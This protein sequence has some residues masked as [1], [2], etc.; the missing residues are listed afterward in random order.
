MLPSL[1]AEELRDALASYLG[2]TFALADD[3]VRERLEAFLTDPVDGIFRGPYVRLRLPF[4]PAAEG[5]EDVL[6]WAPP[7][8]RPYHHQAEAFRRL[9]SKHG[10]P[11][12]TLVTTGTGSGK[13]EAF[14]IPLLDHCRRARAAGQPGIKA[15]VLYPMNALANDQAQRIDALLR[16]NAEELGEITVGLYTGDAEA[17][18][19][20][21]ADSLLRQRRELRENPPDILLTNYKMLDFL[22]LRPEDAELWR[23]SRDSLQYVVLDE[24]HTYDGAQGTDVAMLLRRLSMTLGV[25]RPGRPLGQ[26]TP[27]ATSATLGDGGETNSTLLDFAGR[28]FG[29]PFDATAVIR[30]NRLSVEE[31]L[32]DAPPVD[33]FTYEALPM[34][35]QL[36]PPTPG[37]PHL[38]RLAEVARVFLRDPAATGGSAWGNPDP[39]IVSDRHRL[40][41]RLKHHPLTAKLLAAAA[42][43]RPLGDLV[44]EVAPDWVR[45]RDAAGQRALSDFLA[46]LSHARSGDRP[47]LQVEI[48]LWI[49]EVSRIDRAV[50][51]VPDFRWGSDSPRTD[52][53]QRYLP[54]IYCRHCGRSG[55]GA[56]RRSS[57][58]ALD[59]NPQHIRR[60][61]ARN[62]GRFRALIYAPGEDQAGDRKALSWLDP[63]TLELHARRPSEEHEL[64]P[65]LVTSDD[66]AA[67]KERCPS[68]GLD[69][70]IRFLGSRVATLTSVAVGHVFASPDVDPEQ[71]KTLLFTDSVQDAAHRAGFIEARSYTLN[72]RSLLHRALGGDQGN[73]AEIGSKLLNAATTPEDR[74][75]LLPP[76]MA[77]DEQYREFWAS[78]RCSQRIRSEVLNRV[79]FGAI[80]EFGLHAR[81]G[82]TLEL[83]GTITAH[84]DAE[85]EW[86]TRVARDV[87]A[88]HREERPQFEELSGEG[89]LLGW[90]RGVLERMRLQGGI[91]HRWLHRYI[92]EDGRR[93]TIWGG[94]PEGMPAFPSGRPAPAF[95]TTVARYE[96][97]DSVVARNTWYT[98]WTART[99]EIPESEAPHLVRR[100]FEHL[101]AEN[102]ISAQATQSGATVYYLE[103]DQV[104]LTPLDTEPDGGV[105]LRCDVCSLRFPGIAEIAQQL[106]DRPCLRNRCPGRL[107]E[108][109][110]GPD[111]Y[112][113][114]YSSGRVRRI[115]T[116]E[117]TGLLDADTRVRVEKAF[118]TSQDP[119]APNV[120][121]CT[122]TLELGIDIG[123]L[124]VVGLTSLPRTV[125]GYLQRVGRAGRQTGNALVLAVLPGRGINL[126]WLSEPLEM[127]AGEVIPPACYLDAAEIL[128]RQYF[129]SLVDRA[130]RT[131]RGRPPRTAGRMLPTALARGSWLYDLLQDARKNAAVYVE[132]FLAGFRGHITPAT[133]AMLAEWAGVGL[134]AT[135]IS[136]MERTVEA[137]VRRWNDDFAELGVRAQALQNEIRRLEAQ[138]SIL[139]DE[140]ERDL[141][142]VRGEYRI[143]VSERRAMAREYWISAFEALGLLPN[144]NLLDDRTRLDVSLTWTDE[145]TGRA[146]VER[147]SYERGSRIALE[148][149]A[150]GN[151]FY[152]N[153]VA[154]SVDAVDLG[155]EH[156][157]NLGRWRFCPS[158]GW[159]APNSRPTACPRCHDSRAADTGQVLT[160]V[161]FRRASAFASRDNA[162]FGDEDEER[163]RTR[164]T[165]LSAVDVAPQRITRAW[166]LRDYPFGAEYARA[167][168]IR[169][170]NLGRQDGGGAEQQI[171]GETVQAPLFVVCRY[172]GVV[173]EAQPRVHDVA[174]ARHRGWC[175]Q[176][177]EP[178]P[179]GWVSVALLHELR[180]EVVRLLVPPIVIADD[181]LL[182]SVRAA[183]LLGLRK[184]LGGEPDH[185]DVLIA[186]DPGHRGWFTLVLHDR[187]PG[188]TGYLA[189][190][191]DPEAVRALL[192]AAAKALED[193]PCA[194]QPIKAC[195]RCLLPY[196]PPWAVPDVRRDLA[197]GL[198]RDILAAWQPQDLTSL[199]AIAVSPHETP[200][201]QRL[202][203][204]LTQWA[205][206]QN[207]DPRLSPGPGGDQLTFRL[208][209]AEGTRT[210]TMV[211]QPRLG[212][213]QPDFVLQADDPSVPEIAVFCDGRKYHATP[214]HNRLADD[215]GKRASLREQG[216]LVWAIT[217]EDLDSFDEVLRGSPSVG[218]AALTE[219]QRQALERLAN[220]TRFF[221]PGQ[222]RAGELAGD[223][224]TLL[225]QY[226]LR[227]RREVW[228]RPIAGLAVAL[229]GG[230]KSNQ[231]RVSD[232]DIR[233]ALT[234]VL[235]GKEV[236]PSA[237]GTP[238]L[239]RHTAG[240]AAALVDVHRLPQVRVFLGVDDRAEVMGGPDHEQAWRDWLALSNL[241][242]FLGPE[243][244]VAGTASAP[245]P[246]EVEP[247]TRADSRANLS[248]LDPRWSAL[249]GLLGPAMDALVSELATHQLPIPEPGFEARNGEIV[250]DLAWPD[251]K[252]A[253]VMDEDQ[254]RDELLRADGWTVLP[255]DTAMITS[256]L[257][258]GGGDR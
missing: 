158:C 81:T 16:A 231:V 184:M 234:A 74:Y 26:I 104:V 150:P 126:H 229:T 163:R 170:V 50:V 153:G 5:W 145:R 206:Q 114:L 243:C 8:F 179:D 134:P 205:K 252:V 224:V 65:V 176:R 76:D 46:L 61:S 137:A 28:V 84:V 133:E 213:V 118:K 54:A 218:L 7:G 95:P 44:R 167:A 155:T 25:S 208:S 235:H 196:T 3:E 120:L 198:L 230:D 21:G 19:Q 141:K 136:P 58:T 11:Q 49:R 41:L 223:A 152:V 69:D 94:R 214:E 159:S 240:G 178:D 9:S 238:I 37:R 204:L 57:E 34:L 227:P 125:A 210:W 187:V 80:L 251:R 182:Q 96:G 140:G 108:R 185:L 143:A 217:H 154:I 31:W 4:R 64:L 115:S 192:S 20:S 148:E 93:W 91:H 85:P 199:A 24:F 166:G 177:H 1:I 162:R 131:G 197:L 72:F 59:A 82:R 242:Q 165:I 86:I 147:A 255:P 117:H 241:L 138:Q 83:T 14:L 149:L 130:A 12:P 116:H 209:T 146:A 121:T 195:H 75:A 156:N 66:E 160:A 110:F 2:T 135:E 62:Q 68:C 258:N 71:K 112:R 32:G 15:L 55:W 236:I 180:T 87:L 245:V 174:D 105:L 151:T 99:L 253:V 52:L 101:A 248:Q 168:D 191:A 98:N 90:V 103:P 73:L 18:Q 157:P 246:G 89:D 171:A 48:Q 43:P 215:A 233:E 127:I 132:E 45:R 97:F 63:I 39:D 181:T 56:A 122:P 13:T 47:L 169:W 254:G 201:E 173:P 250:I 225:T 119:D 203:A 78:R 23:A 193:C 186:P 60:L 38:E 129:A 239:V 40:G 256:T 33:P 220:N 107:R 92:Q 237:D 29:E 226:L 190:F 17:G 228:E 10:R 88:E 51:S 164:Y 257:G 244:F 123:D 27:V 200:I 175:R 144:Y 42:T 102:I 79:T 202:R 70:G 124:S 113:R 183:L 211:A 212:F 247:A 172:C 100:L 139:D 67:K 36:P 216:Y 53:D 30:E 142:R 189:Q 222:V 106:C 77:N 221:G 109:R 207:A 161:R 188:G 219:K 249:L 194:E 128:R 22:L 232:Q 111:Y 6:D 35:E